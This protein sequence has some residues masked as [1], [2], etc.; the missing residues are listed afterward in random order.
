MTLLS[1][2]LSL[3]RSLCVSPLYLPWWF[4]PFTL[5]KGWSFPVVSHKVNSSMA[6]PPSSQSKNTKSQPTTSDE[7]LVQSKIP[8]QADINMHKFALNIVFSNSHFL[9]VMVE[10]SEQVSGKL[11][12]LEVEDPPA[13]PGTRQMEKPVIRGRIQLNMKHWR[14]RRRQ[15]EAEEWA[16]GKQSQHPCVIRRLSFMLLGRKTNQLGEKSSRPLLPHPCTR[17]PTA[18]YPSDASPNVA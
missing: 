9:W 16:Q 13:P 14:R 3:F 8:T 7:A 12:Q 10:K 6:F 18:R 17:P 1:L 15:E 11:K 2:S 4:K 5:D